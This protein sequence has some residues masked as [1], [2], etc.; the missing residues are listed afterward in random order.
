M[1]PMQ[2]SRAKW[3]RLQLGMSQVQLAREIGI[4]S[5]NISYLEKGRSKVSKV[6][7]HKIA[8][9]LGYEG[10]PSDLLDVIE[11]DKI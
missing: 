5:P 3:L 10:A 1:L 4:A 2:I 8:I 9:R 7:M 6:L 11:V